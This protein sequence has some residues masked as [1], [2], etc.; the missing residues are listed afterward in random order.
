M[1]TNCPGP[2]DRLLIYL[3]LFISDCLTKLAAAPGR[4]SPSYGEAQKKLQTLSVD[5]F[6]LPGEPGFPLNQM[7]HPP[8]SRHESGE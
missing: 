7:Y 1:E 2:A 4:P 5:S 3:I 8:A 6:A